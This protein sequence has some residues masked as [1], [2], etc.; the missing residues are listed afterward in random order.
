MLFLDLLLIKKVFFLFIEFYGLFPMSN[1]MGE[2]HLFDDDIYS[3]L[4]LLY[5][6]SLLFVLSIFNDVL[7]FFIFLLLAIVFFKVF[8]FCLPWLL[9]SL[10]TC[11]L[12]LSLTGS[13]FCLLKYKFWLTILDVCAFLIGGS[14]NWC[15]V[16]F[17]M[18]SWIF[19]FYFL[20]LDIY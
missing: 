15:V 8:L 17:Y 18:K 3:F 10:L 16:F 14:E 5:N 4:R 6:W 1:V 11:L 12:L 2:M 20:Y 13:L 7:I 19:Y 9:L